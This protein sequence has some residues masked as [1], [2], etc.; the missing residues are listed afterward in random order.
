MSEQKRLLFAFGH[1]DDEANLAGSTI[2]KYSAEGASVLVAIATRGEVGDIAPGSH[3]TAATLGAVR[4]AELRA[5]IAVLGASLELFD[6]RDSGMPGA[7]ENADPRAFV[8]APEAE[9]LGKL[10][11]LMRR[12]WPHVVVTFDEHGGYGHPDHITISK[13]TTLAFHAC[14]DE[15]YIDPRS[16]P[17][18]TPLKL[19]YMGI[20]REHIGRWLDA[21]T[22]L[23]P[24]NAY[25]HLDVESM[26]MPINEYTARLD[27]SAYIDKRREAIAQHRSEISLFDMFPASMRQEVFSQ[28]Y[29]A[30]IHPQ[31]PHA[32]DRLESDLFEGI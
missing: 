22:R 14:G 19:Y 10:T 27:V 20:P 5:S 1:P 17:T 18:W 15:G 13:T 31:R 4:E 32:V 2:A 9:V 12:H 25:R 8:Q 29:F 30:L 23:K 6:Y 28:D 26:Y 7:P 16:L 11:T 3:A 24:D 21:Y